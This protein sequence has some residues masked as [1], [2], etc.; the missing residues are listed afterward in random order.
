MRPLGNLLSLKEDMKRKGWSISAFEFRYK[1]VDYF[2]LVK[3]FVDISY[4]HE[5]A[6]VRLTFVKADNFDDNFEVDANSSGLMLREEDKYAEFLHFFGIESKENN[7]GNIFKEFAVVLGRCVPASMPEVESYSYNIKRAM[8]ISLNISDS[9]DPNKIYLYA[10]RQNP[11]GQRRSIYN[12]DKTGLL[13]P[14]LFKV[15]KDF[16]EISFCYSDD[17]SK[18]KSDADVV[19]D[20]I[21]NGFKLKYYQHSN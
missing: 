10:V 7:P 1:D 2:V 17:A 5:F 19:R 13:R 3:R 20:A 14:Q 11:K 15:F 12:S 9:E 16:S 6:L 4:I 21:N 18:E 8:V